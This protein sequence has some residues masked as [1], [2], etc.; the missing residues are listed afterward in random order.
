VEDTGGVIEEVA[1]VVVWR[2]K[3]TE[4]VV[5]ELELCDCFVEI[6]VAVVFAS[7]VV[8]ETMAELLV[9]TVTGTDAFVVEALAVTNEGRIVVNPVPFVLD[10]LEIVEP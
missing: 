10:E 5:W 8:E 4:V 1:D 6:L 3:T 7:V 9:G 2:V